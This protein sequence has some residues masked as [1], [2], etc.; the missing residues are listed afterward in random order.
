MITL[1]KLL[2]SNKKSHLIFIFLIISY[3]FPFKVF[4]SNE[5]LTLEDFI[6]QVIERFPLILVAEQERAIAEGRRLSAV[7][8]FDFNF[9]NQALMRPLGYYETR[10]FSS[11]IEKPL[12]TYGMNVYGTYRRGAGNFPIY[13]GKDV[14]TDG[15]EFGAGVQ[16]PLLRNREIDS[17]RGGLKTTDIGIDLADQSIVLQKIDIVLRATFLYWDWVAT[18]KKT[19]I[20]NTLVD[21]AKLRDEGIVERVKQGD[22]PEF[23]R[24]DNLRNVLE[25]ESQL[26][27]AE[28]NFQE[29]SI[30]LSL[31]LRDERGS[32]IMPL[33]STLPKDF[34][35]PNSTFLSEADLY[36]KALMKRPELKSIILEK[37]QNRIDI[38]LAENDFSPRLDFL[39]E[40][41][42][43]L[44]GRDKTREDTELESGFIFEVPLERRVSRGK[45]ESTKAKNLQLNN[46]EKFIREQILAEVQDAI[47]SIQNAKEL[48]KIVKKEYEFADKLEKGERF[49]FEAGESTILIVNLREQATA[50]TAVRKVDAMAQYHKAEAFL[51]AT[52]AEGY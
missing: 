24:M 40:V 19:D 33:K 17:R 42:K 52:I 12:E 36:K 27:R 13:E 23:E 41:S 16:V 15:G 1:I 39:M 28:R 11:I 48:I 7:G 8:A 44:G 29:A 45:I 9:R 5:V 26:V 3:L 10:R 6:S 32:P 50:D 4:A 30:K 51:K 31:F 20:V 47:S 25:R 18:G 46:Q 49:R 35:D 43:D 37:D 14:T 21:T 38:E 34:P 2:N 22:L